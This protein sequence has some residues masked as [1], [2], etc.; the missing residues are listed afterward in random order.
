MSKQAISVIP[1]TMQGCAVP[2]KY[3]I[4]RRSDGIGR[5]SAKKSWRLAQRSGKSRGLAAHTEMLLISSLSPIQQLPPA[6]KPSG[7]PTQLLCRETAERVLLCRE[8]SSKYEGR[9]IVVNLATAIWTD[10]MVLR[11]IHPL[12]LQRCWQFS[13]PRFSPHSELS[14]IKRR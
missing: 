2:P 10:R 8:E 1:R 7:Q 12:F 13:S 11:R 3:S 6:R 9:G 5:R 4:G 14:L